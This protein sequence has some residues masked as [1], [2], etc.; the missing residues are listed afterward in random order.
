MFLTPRGLLALGGTALWVVAVMI[1]TPLL[2]PDP[3]WP[4]GLRRSGVETALC[5]VFGMSVA[6]RISRT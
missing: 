5:L 1:V 6:A 2:L 3:L 4:G